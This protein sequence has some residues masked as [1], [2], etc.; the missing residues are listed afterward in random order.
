MNTYER[1]MHRQMHTRVEPDDKDIMTLGSPPLVR[2]AYEL[3]RTSLRGGNLAEREDLT[4]PALALTIGMDVAVVQDAVAMLANEGLVRIGPESEVEIGPRMVQIPV[5]DLVVRDPSLLGRKIRN[6]LRV[7]E[8]EH[9]V[10]RSTP[11]IRER[12]RSTASLVLMVEQLGV[13]DE[14]PIY[15]RVGYYDEDDHHALSR[16]IIAEDEQATRRP[17]S[18]VFLDLFGIPL[19]SCQTS[20]EAVRCEAGTAQALGIEPGTPVLLRESLILDRQ[21]RPR[22]LSYTHYRSDRVSLSDAL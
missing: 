20:V 12:L 19:A 4:I 14:Q 21:G 8:L 3:I 11:V 18:T 1:T 22:A 13:F 2:R 15:L 9:K 7:V 6:D 17:M 5:N 10:V 16:R